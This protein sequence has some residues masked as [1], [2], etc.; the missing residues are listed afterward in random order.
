MDGHSVAPRAARGL[1]APG[2]RRPRSVDEQE[3][4]SSAERRPRERDDE[5][6]G[7]MATSATAPAR[8]SRSS[9]AVPSGAHRT[10]S[11][12][13]T[14]ALHDATRWRGSRSLVE[15]VG[16]GT[17]EILEPERVGERRAR[18][19]DLEH[20][21]AGG[22]DLLDERLVGVGDERVAARAGAERRP[23]SRYSRRS[24]SAGARCRRARTRR[25]RR[26]CCPRRCWRR[27]GC[28]R[29][30]AGG[31]VAP[32]PRRRFRRSPAARAATA[33][34]RCDRRP[35]RPGS[36]PRTC[37]RSPSS[38]SGGRC[39]GSP[40][41]RPPPVDSNTSRGVPPGSIS[42]MLLQSDS[43]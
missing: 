41:T 7:Q 1:E 32:R 37:R 36:D 11:A 16:R 10:G 19:P 27:S 28:R 30:A 4:A 26:R 25:R 20:H 35:A 39:R 12:A 18:D 33:R 8:A 17:V 43:P 9:D 2:R 15:D 24:R 34:R 6:A 40:W 31:R 23:G 14:N 5:R 29:R 42:K 3:R 22:V 21:G 38:N 13:A